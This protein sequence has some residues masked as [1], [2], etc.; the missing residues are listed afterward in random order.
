MRKKIIIS[1]VVVLMLFA[2][3]PKAQGFDI[4]LIP[5]PEH[6]TPGLTYRLH[7]ISF[8]F[9]N[10]YL[11]VWNR[12]GRSEYKF[13][14]DEDHWKEVSYIKGVIPDMVGCKVSKTYKLPVRK[15]QATLRNKRVTLQTKSASNTFPARK[16]FSYET[17][18]RI[19]RREDTLAGNFF[20]FYVQRDVKEFVRNKV[21]NKGIFFSHFYSSSL[22][23]TPA[24]ICRRILFIDYTLGGVI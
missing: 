14:W 2:F 18:L 9:N 24:S 23:T 16:E 12:W 17:I 11:L 13:Q 21:P 20:T 8:L 5:S 7:G 22:S 1:M 4:S 10:G 19:Q 6:L 15:E 3:V